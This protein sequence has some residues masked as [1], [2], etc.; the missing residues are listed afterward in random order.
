MR[1]IEKFVEECAMLKFALEVGQEELGL[2]AQHVFFIKLLDESDDESER[3]SFIG[4]EIRD[5]EFLHGARAVELS[6]NSVFARREAEVGVGA[7]IF[8]DIVPACTIAQFADE[9]AFRAGGFPFGYVE[10]SLQ[11]T[12]NA[13]IALGI[14]LGSGSPPVG[15]GHFG[16]RV[17]R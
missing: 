14:S 1:G 16:G 5:D 15:N 7:R 11:G 10:T 12:P 17:V 13:G 4:V 8:E 9:D 2:I 3:E 6:P